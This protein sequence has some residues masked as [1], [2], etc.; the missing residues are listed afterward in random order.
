VDVGRGA[1]LVIGWR[2]VVGMWGECLTWDEGRHPSYKVQTRGGG[3][4]QLPVG[5]A[6]FTLLHF[7]TQGRGHLQSICL[8]HPTIFI[9][10]DAC[11]FDK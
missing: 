4:L 9:N 2:R 5:Q 10:F 11:G 8:D 6:G 1:G 7:V 3:Q